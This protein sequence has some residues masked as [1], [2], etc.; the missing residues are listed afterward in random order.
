[1]FFLLEIILMLSQAKT[2]LI[3]KKN[4]KLENCSIEIIFI[5]WIAVRGRLFAGSVD[6]RKLKEEKFFAKDVSLKG[7]FDNVKITDIAGLSF[8][9]N[10][11]GSFQ[12][13]WN[14]NCNT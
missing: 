1:M 9:K 6:A 5:E 10:C 12:V 8:N 13:L 2:I 7:S 11:L 4:V 3:R 14:K